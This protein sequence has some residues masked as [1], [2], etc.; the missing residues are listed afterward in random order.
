MSFTP[1][2][3][4]ISVLSIGGAMHPNLVETQDN[5][6]QQKRHKQRALFNEVHSDCNIRFE[7]FTVRTP[8]RKWEKKM[9]GQ[10]PIRANLEIPSQL[11]KEWPAKSQSVPLL[12][13]LGLLH[14]PPSPI[15]WPFGKA[16]LEPFMGV[17]PTSCL[18]PWNLQP[19]LSSC[20]TFGEQVLVQHCCDYCTRT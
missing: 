7:D 10:Q 18:V 11:S 20:E 9:P 14:C 5:I 17:L 16:A 1:P 2:V 13:L 3:E 8:Q 12:N 4:N 19:N 6:W 15:D